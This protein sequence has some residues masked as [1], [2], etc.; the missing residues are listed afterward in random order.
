M[1]IVVVTFNYRV[2]LYRFLASTEVQEEH[3]SLNNGLKDQI[4]ALHWVQEHIGKFDGDPNHAV[5]GGDSVGAAS[6]TLLLK[7]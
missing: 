3:A 4:K 1:S 6:I 5:L 2:G 7:A